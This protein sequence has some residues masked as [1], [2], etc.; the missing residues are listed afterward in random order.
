MESWGFVDE[1][2]S[3]EDEIN[4]SADETVLKLMKM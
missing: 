3:N 2:G 1:L 4:S